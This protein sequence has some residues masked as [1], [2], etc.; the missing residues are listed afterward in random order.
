MRCTD[1][2]GR[3]HEIVSAFVA[4]TLMF[5]AAAMLSLAAGAAIGLALGYAAILLVS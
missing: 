1:G 2:F 4:D 3:V 5:V